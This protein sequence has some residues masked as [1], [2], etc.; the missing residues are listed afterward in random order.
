MGSDN[1]GDRCSLNLSLLWKVAYQSLTYQF[2]ST[3]GRV[4]MRLH[5]DR[6]EAY[7]PLEELFPLADSGASSHW[8]QSRI[9][10]DKQTW[11]L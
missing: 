6:T 1:Q 5:V 10:G 3:I 4:E 11:P 8:V 9:Y 7:A 2:D